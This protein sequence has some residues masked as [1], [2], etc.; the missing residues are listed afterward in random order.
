MNDIFKPYLRNLVLDFF[1]NILV[2]SPSLEQHYKHLET[3]FQILITNR[4]YVKKSKCTFAQAQ[5]VYLGHIISSEGVQI[6]LV[7]LKQ[8]YCGPNLLKLRN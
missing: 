8:C 7:R 5:V 3:V 1:D 2:Y 4:L 6:V